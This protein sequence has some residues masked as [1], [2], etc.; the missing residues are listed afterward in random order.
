MHE[1]WGTLVYVL[2][3]KGTLNLARVR[4]RE[5]PL[6]IGLNGSKLPAGA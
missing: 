2:N 4:R 5:I 6:L 1:V 3:Q